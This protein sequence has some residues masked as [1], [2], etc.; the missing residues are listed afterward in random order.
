V[1]MLPAFGLIICSKHLDISYNLLL[2]VS[3][4]KNLPVR[5]QKEGVY[6]LKYNKVFDW[7]SHCLKSLQPSV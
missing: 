7:Y 5:N 1:L 6:H 3:I 2:A 4:K